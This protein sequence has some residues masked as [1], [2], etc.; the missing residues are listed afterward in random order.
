MTPAERPTSIEIDTV[1]CSSCSG[2]GEY[3]WGEMFTR[4]GTCDGRGEIDVCAQCHDSGDECAACGVPSDEFSGGDPVEVRPSDS[5]AESQAGLNGP[6]GSPTSPPERA[7]PVD[8]RDRDRMVKCGL[9]A[10]APDGTLAFTDL[11]LRALAAVAWFT[12]LPG[13]ERIA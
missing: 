7:V 5:R 3:D 13:D 6:S 11:G 4:C 10:V 2:T 9:V 1:M 8:Q 12:D